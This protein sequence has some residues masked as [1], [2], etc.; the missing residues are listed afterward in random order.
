[1]PDSTVVDNPRSDAVH[2]LSPG[3]DLAVAL[4]GFRP[5]APQQR[6][7]A[8]VEAALGDAPTA[9]LVEAATGVGKTFAYLVPV[10]Q[11]RR[12]AL[13]STGTK[14]LQDQLFERDLPTVCEA[15]GYT[16]RR[17]L[18]KGRANYLCHYRLELASAEAGGAT[19]RG[20]RA[21]R[22]PVL[23]ALQRYARTSDSGDL[24]QA[25]ILAEDS[26]LWPQVT[27]TVDNCLGGECPN[28]Q[29]C[30]VLRARKRAQEADVVVVNHH[31]LLADMAL[32]EEGFGDLLPEVDAVIVDEA[33]QLPDIA[34]SFFGVALGTRALRELARDT[35]REQEQQVSEAADIRHRVGDLETAVAALLEISADWEAR[36]AHADIAADGRLE[37]CLDALD[38]ALGQLEQ[39]L[40]AVAARAAGLEQLRGR[41]AMLQARL[42]EWREDT[43]DTVPWAERFRQSLTLHRTPLDAARPLAQRRAARPATWVF[44]SATLAVGE[45]FSHAARR[46][47]LPGD[48]ATERLDSPFDFARQACLVH[49]DPALPDPNSRAYTRACIAWAWPLLRDNPGGGFF[50][51]TSHRALQE[52]ALILRSELPDGRELLVQGEQP[53]GDLLER[54]RA[55]GTAWLLGAHSFW[56]GV[57]IRGDALSIVIIDRLPFAAPNDPVLQARAAALEAEGRSPFM[58]YSLPQAVLALKQ[59]AG[60]LIRDA[61][62][63]GIL[64]LCDPRLT[65]KSYGRQFLASLPPFYR[66]R[67]PAEAL[68]FLQAAR[69]NPAC[70]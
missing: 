48:V 34:G 31:L 32:K 13:I 1:M 4:A 23:E 54:F 16:P 45:D 7:A 67:E 11:A 55:S 58:E 64:A 15:L 66:A 24:G 21:E 63:A 33:H 17:A 20:A 42:H 53:R 22:L 37:G 18:L 5:R 65:G 25:G 6:M 62:D 69:E 51:F 41:C 56:E 3:G 43:P 46:L 12:R 61:E 68:R 60:R 10:L 27:S 28:L 8:A 36:S 70:V 19:G 2:A 39:A 30:F 49:P 47:G 9:L 44:T 40:E 38:D 52:A 59:G 26:P 29:D 50:L 57:D 14:T 35:R